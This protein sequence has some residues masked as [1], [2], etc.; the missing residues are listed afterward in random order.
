M[1]PDPVLAHFDDVADVYDEALPFFATFASEMVGELLPRSG[2][3]ALDLAAGRGAIA[4]ELLRRGLEVVAVDGAPRMVE[5]LRRDVP[6]V[7]THVMDATD[8]DLPHESFDL[9]TCGFALH[10]V[11]DARA[12]LAGIERVLAPGG[13]AAFTIGGRAD[14]A[15][16]PWSDPLAD[17]YEEF[18]RYQTDGSGLLSKDIDEEQLLHE[19]FPEVS[20]TTIE[21]SIPVADGETY[22]RWA[23]SHGS[24][25]FLGRLPT[26]KRTAM[27]SLLLERVAAIPGFRLRRSAT[28]WVARKPAQL[29]HAHVH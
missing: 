17:L 24:R 8:L 26:E 18:R 9:V 5:L 11:S 25:T 21:V 23:S 27:R 14:G 16:D 19:V 7:E 3:R 6:E 4:S 29:G 13:S 22:W 1:E 2:T 20:S 12:A 15:P 10:L 28:L